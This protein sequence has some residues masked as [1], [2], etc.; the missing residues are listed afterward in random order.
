MNLSALIRMGAS[1]YLAVMLIIAT[2]VAVHG[3]NSFLWIAHLWFAVVALLAAFHNAKGIAAEFRED[4]GFWFLALFLAY[5]VLMAAIHPDPEVSRGYLKDVVRSCLVSVVAG[6]LVSAA[7]RVNPITDGAVLLLMGAGLAAIFFIAMPQMREDI[8]LIHQPQGVAPQYQ[9]FGDHLSLVAVVA[10]VLLAGI[11]G[12]WAAS[13]NRS[14]L[15]VP[16]LFVAAFMAAQLVGSNNATVL[17]GLIALSL[18]A[19]TIWGYAKFGDYRNLAAFL[20]A[21]GIAVTIWVALIVVLPPMRILNFSSS[22][23]VLLSGDEGAVPGYSSIASRV[24][25]SGHSADQFRVSP[26]FGDLAADK[27]SGESGE[28]LHSILS[29]QTHLGVV[30]SLLLAGFFIF[31]LRDLYSLGPDIRKWIAPPILLIAFLA[32][33][34]TWQVLW[35][36]AGILLAVPKK[37]ASAPRGLALSQQ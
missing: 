21:S 9:Y 27:L 13:A 6:Y 34:F 3:D 32:T 18:G 8:F 2:K 20:V 7:V 28:Y 23:E 17:L 22:G 33:F 36:L 12:P 16:F 26:I 5:L 11:S 37:S 4:P 29:V 14:W 19:G 31:K 10:T 35:L 15:V 24:D 30:G 1:V 25:I